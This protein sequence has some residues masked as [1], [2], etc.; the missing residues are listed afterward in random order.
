[1]LPFY[2]KRTAASQASLRSKK[3]AGRVEMSALQEISNTY[4]SRREID[5]LLGLVEDR[6]VSLGQ[7]LVQVEGIATQADARAVAVTQSTASFAST[8]ETRLAALRDFLV[9]QIETRVGRDSWPGLVQQTV[10]AAR[11]AAGA[12]VHQLLSEWQA[13][14]VIPP[15]PQ[16][17]TPPFFPETSPLP[18]V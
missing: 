7:R 4:Y 3:R 1:M 17:E 14:Q 13:A 15:P 8:G 2:P 10:E 11:D 6:L 12:T 5:E 18:S 16:P 9:S